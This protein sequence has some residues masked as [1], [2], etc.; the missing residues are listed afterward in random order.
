MR[1]LLIAPFNSTGIRPGQFLAPPIGLYRLKLFLEK[2]DKDIKCEIL[3]SNLYPNDPIPQQFL[4]EYDVIGSSLL[5]G[6]IKSALDIH[7]AILKKS[8]PQAFSI[9]GGQGIMG[10]NLDRILN[11]FSFIKAITLGLGEVPLLHLV[12]ALHRGQYLAGYQR[13]RFQT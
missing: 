4:Y 12:R 9:C 10:K 5:E 8:S 11:T 1:V 3:D 2:N 7:E 13:T 6:P